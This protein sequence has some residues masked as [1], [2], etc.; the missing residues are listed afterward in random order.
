VVGKS[1]GIAMHVLRAALLYFGVVF[2][3]G[4]I[5]GVIRTLW[6]A[7]RFSART[8]E[9]MEAP[10]MLVVTIIAAR[11]IV[12]R[13]PAPAM[14]SARLEMGGIALGLMLLAEFGLVAW[15]RGISIKK[16]CATRDPVSGTVYYALLAVFA[17]MPLL[18]IL[19]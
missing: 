10:L 4:F 11:W 18:L 13:L 6:V 9:L 8:A 3:A 2:G 19:R 7:R 1:S 14:S 5:L 17:L 12:A 16:Y 15:L